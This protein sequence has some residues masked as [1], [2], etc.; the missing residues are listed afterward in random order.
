M[1]LS[2]APNI[3]FALCLLLFQSLAPYAASAAGVEPALERQQGVNLDSYWKA[4]EK[5]Y[6]AGTDFHTA[7]RWAAGQY[8]VEGE[9]EEGY[10]DTVTEFLLVRKEKEGWVVEIET[11]D[12]RGEHVNQAL[13]SGLEDAIDADDAGKLRLL[14]IKSVGKDGAII[15][16]RKGLTL[17]L[18]NHMARPAAAKL[19][20]NLKG[21]ESGG[22]VKVPAGSF[23]D[24]SLKIIRTRSL[25]FASE[26]R[27]WYNSAV[28]VNG[29][30]KCVSEGGK[31]VIELLAFGLNGKPK[32]VEDAKNKSDN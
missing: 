15:T 32:I 10:R 12:K 13:V 4:S 28:P 30:V 5:R 11:V 22:A 3:G 18:I 6:K 21:H 23:A 8:V 16:T 26:T 20:A 17:D 25:F 31:R 27:Y 29:L 1:R 9:T 7:R 24:T 2:R 19:I 14:W